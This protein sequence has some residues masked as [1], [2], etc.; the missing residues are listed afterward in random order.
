MLKYCILIPFAKAG[1][2]CSL[3]VGTQDICCENEGYGP[4]CYEITSN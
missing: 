3:S 1:Y 4:I 2:E